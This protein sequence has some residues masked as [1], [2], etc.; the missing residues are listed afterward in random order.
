MDVL[1]FALDME[2]EGERY[3]RGQAEKFADT[4]LKPVFDLLAKDEAKHAGIIRGKMDGTAYE[5][6]ADEQLSDRE[7]LFNGLKDYKP[8]AEQKPDQAELYRSALEIEQ[9]SIDL[10]TDLR[11]KAEDAQTQALFDFLIQE[12]TR[13]RQ[14]LEDMYRFVNRPN[15]WVESAEFGL[16]EDY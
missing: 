7:S 4:P 16:R 1:Q 3:Y 6:K 12:E 8:L 15:E 13:H 14:I 11:G 2:L 10:Y 9:K 5:L